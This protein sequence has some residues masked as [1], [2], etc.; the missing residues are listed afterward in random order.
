VYPGDPQ[1]LEE[2]TRAA[3]EWQSAETGKCNGCG[4]PLDEST[5]KENSY[6]Y[7][8]EAIRCHGCYAIHAAESAKAKKPPQETAGERWRLTKVEVADGSE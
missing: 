5:K 8:A 2:D 1:W 6:A 7:R 3:L 4:Q